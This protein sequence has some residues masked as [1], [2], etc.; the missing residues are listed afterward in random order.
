MN[1]NRNNAI[2][3]KLNTIWISNQR[4]KNEMKVEGKKGNR[5]SGPSDWERNRDNG[6]AAEFDSSFCAR[7]G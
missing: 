7:L 3:T 1:N 5:T 6:C 2:K 4:N